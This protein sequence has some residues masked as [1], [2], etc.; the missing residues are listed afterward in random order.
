MSAK[1]LNVISKANMRTLTKRQKSILKAI[2]LEY[3]KTAKPV[4]S[5]VLQEHYNLSVSSAT[6][7]NEMAN[8]TNMGYITQPHISA[9]RVPTE[10]GYR[11]YITELINYEDNIP[12]EKIRWMQ[13]V[14]AQNYQSIDKM[15]KSLMRFLTNISGQVSIIAEPELSYGIIKNINIFK[16]AENKL[17]FVVSLES[18]LDKT[19]IIDCKYQVTDAQLQAI[20][21]YLH[22][23]FTGKQIYQIEHYY[24]SQFEYS[25]VK[26]KNIDNTLLYK[27]LGVLYKALSKVTD[28]KIY[29]DSNIK[30]LEQPE[31]SSKDEILNFLRILQDKDSIIKIFHSHF[32]D[33]YSVIVGDEIGHK[34]FSNLSFVFAKY[35]ILNIPGFIG[36]LG[37]KRMNYMDNIPMVCFASKM[38]TDMTNKGV[39]IPSVRFSSDI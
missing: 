26:S 32:D 3:L 16:I 19:V 37:P 13:R 2:I 34:G 29:Y 9:G 33:D 17:L 21:R 10:E 4:G 15:L 1:I 38:I 7:R 27:L 28:Y 14:L 23:N 5:K 18:G 6:V 20:I 22:K 30:F 11:F 25:N 8:L 35:S 12:E 36:I 39:V 24:L 31:F